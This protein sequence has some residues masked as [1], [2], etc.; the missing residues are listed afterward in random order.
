MR[1]LQLT[2]I[3]LI[4]SIG[5]A[6]SMYGIYQWTGNEAYRLLYNAD[7]IPILRQFEHLKYFGFTFHIVFCFISVI[8]VFYV[9]QFF[10]R[11]YAVLPYV[12][13]YTGGSS[14]LY[15]LSYFTEGPPAAND[16][17]GWFSWTF[18]HLI[19]SG[20]VIFFIHFWMKKRR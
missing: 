15:F 5:L 14:V 8:G 9:L 7:Y 19:Y 6:A 12:I 18:S 11:Q 17:Y 13:V 4:A 10:G 1:F 20:I 2:L 16:F 3:S